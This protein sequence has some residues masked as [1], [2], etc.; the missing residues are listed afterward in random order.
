MSSV[1]LASQFREN[2]KKS[3][4]PL[5]RDGN[6]LIPNIAH[7]FTA[8]QHLY[9]FYEVYDPAKDKSPELAAAKDKATAI[10]NPIH[11]FTSILFFNGKVKTFETPVVEAR[12]LNAP[13]R[14]A[15]VFQF[16]VPLA[17]IKPGFYTC[18]VNVIDDAG[19]TFSFPRLPIL[20]REKPGTPAQTASQSV[21]PSF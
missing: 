18:Q 2:N 14:K 8:D 1:V 5:V 19:G 9:L 4:N 12:Q 7:V 6:E 16:D 21:A 15:T 11:L 13:E 20:I 3:Q 17:Q 10:K